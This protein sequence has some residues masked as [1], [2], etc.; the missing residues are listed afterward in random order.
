MLTLSLKFSKCN[1]QQKR[2]KIAV[3]DNP[4]SFDAHLQG[5]LANVRTNL[6]LPE[7][8]VIGL[9]LHSNFCGGLVNTHVLSNT[10]C[11]GCSRSSKVVDF[12]TNRQGVC[13]F[14]LVINSN[15]GPILHR[16]WDTATYWL[17]IAIC[18]TSLSF[19][20]I[21]GCESFWISG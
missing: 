1:S 3:V 12:C 17:K 19:N 18:P 10:A 14:Q 2:Q 7:I 9:H 16:F 5:T 8:R 13:D 4:L 6:I 21:A 20:T 15:L 11:N